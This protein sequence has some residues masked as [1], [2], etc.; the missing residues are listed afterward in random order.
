MPEPSDMM[1]ITQT[2]GQ[3]GGSAAL[4]LQLLAEQKER[5]WRHVQQLR[6]VIRSTPPPALS[7]VRAKIGNQFS[8]HRY[9]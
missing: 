8:R 6:C 1:D 4:D 9:I 5:E 2:T 7:L 3:P